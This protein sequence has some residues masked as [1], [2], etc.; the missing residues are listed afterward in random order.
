[1]KRLN[2]SNRRVNG[3]HAAFSL[4]LAMTAT[5]RIAHATAEVCVSGDAEL[6]TALNAARSSAMTIKLQQ[7][8]YHLD[9]TVWNNPGA[10]APTFSAGSSLLGGYTANCAG[11]D[12]AV[13]NTVITDGTNA[14]F[15]GANIGGDA[16]IEGITFNLKNGLYLGADAST[17]TA[18]FLAPQLTIRRNVFT[19]TT[20]A[21]SEALDIYWNEDAALGGTIRLV[22]N[23]VYGNTGGSGTTD[24][25]AV[26]FQIDDGK[27]RIE[28]INNT[29]VDNSGSLGGVGVLNFV[30]VPFYAYN[31]ILYGNSGKDLA[32][33]LGT[34]TLLFNN[35]IG[36]HTYPAPAQT[37]VGT[38]TGDPKLDANHRPIEAPPSSAI[39]SGTD[40]V[41]GG[42]PA[43]DLPGRTR[44][45]GSEPD[46]GAFES[47]INDS[48]LLSVTNT[49]DSGPG[50]L[51]AAILSANAV[52]PSAI[53][54]NLGA[55][56]G[57]YVIAPN[58]ELPNITTEVHVL[59]YTQSGSSSNTLNIGDNAVVCVI[60][61]G[62]VHNLVNGFNV[63]VGAPTAAKLSVTGIAFSGFSHAAVN[64]QGSSGHEVD[65][66]RVGGFV[67]G[68]ALDPVGNGVVIGAGVH[69]VTIGGNDPSERNLLDSATGSGVIIGGASGALSA[70]HD[71]Q[72]L[73]N[74]IGVG[75]NPSTASYIDRGNGGS[76]VVIE[77]YSNVLEENYASYNAGAGF[78]F[79]GTDAHDNVVLSNYLGQ[80]DDSIT[81][82]GN[83]AGIVIENS[84]H[85]NKLSFNALM[86]NHGPGVRIV[87]GQHN[88]VWDNGYRGN[89]GLGLDLDVI[90]VMA[91]DNDSTPH[92]ATYAN[93]GQN[94]PVLSA[95]GGGH[96]RG[97]VSGSLTTTPGDYYIEFYASH[98]CDASGHGPGES[99]II[100]TT[101]V[102]VPAASPVNGQNTVTF[103]AKILH[104][105]EIAPAITSLVTDSL[106]NTSE[107]SNCA[108]YL[109]DTI[110]A[111]GFD[112]TI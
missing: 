58:S 31:N 5:A 57:P 20:G 91:N 38:T 86:N 22:N 97:T 82:S 47:S 13:N 53:L 109:D 30:P 23:L 37:P 112:P 32:I 103:N 88:Q 44:I 94:Y 11:R 70:A 85:D 81:D 41:I 68:I 84:A 48:P 36:T 60:I 10:N 51:R 93:R 106:N 66:S 8:T 77:G 89:A 99:F 6:A 28:L 100:G 26:F 43:T 59:G 110:F 3:R 4:V 72:I 9:H 40:S 34:Q 80:L 92:P 73:G 52:G 61:D 2:H 96:T 74:L 50:S 54:F 67:G 18:M 19:Q 29:I 101:H 71:I 104:W 45:V 56:C 102:T 75:W 17:L 63:A 27:P 90:G 62:G 25:G 15:D 55:T 7:N 39:N 35:V 33:N 107:F 65:G 49:N 16:T 12:I 46:R 76:G 105:F 1:M 87:S 79:T 69:D 111:S 64:L 14:L 83:A 108:M 21:A 98:A 42:L 95:A 78:D 24:A